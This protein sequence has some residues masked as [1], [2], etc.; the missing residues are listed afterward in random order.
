MA[1]IEK[2]FMTPRMLARDLHNFTELCG[3]RGCVL[4]HAL[5]P[6]GETFLRRQRVPVAHCDVISDGIGDGGLRLY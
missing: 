3:L 6:G 1:R 5:L 4:R 2:S